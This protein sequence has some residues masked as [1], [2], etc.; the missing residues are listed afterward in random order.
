[1]LAAATAI[2]LAAAAQAGETF[3]DTFEDG[4]ASADLTGY[5][6]TP[7]GDAT[8]AD[9]E[10]AI[11]PG[12]YKSGKALKVITGTDPLCRALD[13]S[14]GPNAVD[15]TKIESLYIDTMVQFTVTPAGDTV[16]TT[17]EDK[18][19]IFLAEVTN[20]TGVVTGTNL[21]VKSRAFTPANGRDLAVW[22]EVADYELKGI[23][24]D[25]GEWYHLVVEASLNENQ[26]TQFRIKMAKGDDT[27][28]QLTNNDA[29]IATDN[30]LFPSIQGA[31]SAENAP[32]ACSLEYVGFAGE[33][34]VDDLAVGTVTTV[35]PVDFTLALGEGVS[36]VSYTVGDVP[37]SL[38]TAGGAVSIAL[39]G[40]SITLSGI[41]YAPGYEAG[42]ITAKSYQA[43]DITVDATEKTIV[44]E[45]ETLTTGDDIGFTGT[46]F[47]KFTGAD[48]QTV[49]AWAGAGHVAATTVQKMSFNAS[50]GNPAGAVGTPERVAEEAYLLGCSPAEV[51]EEKKEFVF[52]SFTSDMTP[53]AMK[54]AIEAD[55][56]YNGEVVIQG[57]NDLSEGNWADIA[58]DQKC[59]FYRARLKF[60]K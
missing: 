2:G 30:T 10:S 27:L 45:G 49:V 60:G 25:P 57:R 11:V 26:F 7:T 13:F 56:S 41:E 48:L 44:T 46:P 31:Y 32:K 58:A 16:T 20:E 52:P 53:A 39:K 59:N 15:L 23:A 19:M 38:P 14:T 51:E 33:G 18:L 37:G 12:G 35:T 6:F 21:M 9:N 40:T 24:V 17:G 36:A 55:K 28:V 29:L 42:D 47:A 5:S 4:D 8:E 34:M 3:K 22:G 43:G 54:A 50:T 1:M